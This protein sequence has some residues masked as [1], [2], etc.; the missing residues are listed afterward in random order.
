VSAAEVDVMSRLLVISFA[1]LHLSMSI[2]G[3]AV[4]R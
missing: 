1:M 3:A 4:Y 2:D